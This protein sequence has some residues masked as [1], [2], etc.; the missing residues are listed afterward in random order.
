MELSNNIN[1]LTT[2]SA[3]QEGLFRDLAGGMGLS[4]AAHRRKYSTSHACRLV[5]SEAGQ[6]AIAKMRSEI[7][8]ILAENLTEL[9]TQAINILRDQLSSP[10]PD[11]RMA[12]AQFVL[13]YAKPQ[14]LEVTLKATDHA[15]QN[16]LVDT[17][18]PVIRHVAHSANDGTSL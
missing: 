15:T 12:A 6:I 14:E 4:N 17:Q 1:N 8:Q 2:L 16:S 3:R 7:E 13:R 11:R 10:L 18:N 9:V 5:R